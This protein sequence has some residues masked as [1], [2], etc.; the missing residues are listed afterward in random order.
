[1]S[2]FFGTKKVAEKKVKIKPV[3]APSHEELL[4]RL[5]T[6][7][8]YVAVSI[9]RGG[10]SAASKLTGQS[11]SFQN[12]PPLPL[13]QCN[14]SHCTC[15]YQGIAERRHADQRLTERRK[16]LRMEDDRRKNSGRRKEDKLW[17]KNDF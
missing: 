15:E 9:G 13:A 11:F 7:G 8:L 16:S 14:A 5:K 1:M 10:C 3:V 12:A 4:F 6:S 2:W 17:N